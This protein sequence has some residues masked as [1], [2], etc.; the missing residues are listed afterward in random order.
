M[1]PKIITA[2]TYTVT[3]DDNCWWIVL[4]NPGNVTVTLPAPGLIFSPGFQITI[5][6]VQPGTQVTFNQLADDA[7][8]VHQI[9]T[10]PTLTTA[11][12]EG[13]VLKIQQDLNWWVLPT[14]AVGRPLIQT[15]AA[16]QALSTANFAVIT[17]AGFYSL[18][19]VPS[20]FYVASAHAC[21]LNAGAGDNGSQVKSADGKC[22]LAVYPSNI[23]DVREWGAHCDNATDDSV[24][25][26]AALNAGLTV[27]NSNASV[28]VPS[29][30]CMVKGNL[31]IPINTALQCSTPFP[32]AITG[33][34]A[35]NTEPAIV[36]DPSKTISAA[37]PGASISGCFIVASGITFPVLTIPTWTG[38]AVKD[39]GFSDFSLTYST[40]VG[41]DTAF[42][43]TGAR[44]YVHHVFADGTG[45]THAVIELDVGNTDS[46]VADY[47]K[48]QPI[49]TAN[50]CAAGRRPGTGLRVGS[51]PGPAGIWLD[52][53]V[54]QNF[55]IYDYDF[56]TG[57]IFGAIW[58][59]GNN[60]ACA[61]YVGNIGVHVAA[62]N[63]V[64]G[65]SLASFSGDP[66]IVVDATSTLKADFIASEFSG[67]DCIQLSG[68]LVAQT[69]LLLDCAGGAAKILAT[70]GVFSVHNLQMGGNNGGSLPFIKGGTTGLL[71]GAKPWGQVFFDELTTD[72]PGNLFDSN[73]TGTVGSAHMTALMQITPT[74]ACTGIGSTGTCSLPSP[75]ETGITSGTILLTPGG[76]GIAASGTVTVGISLAAAFQVV[77]WAQTTGGDWAAGSGVTPSTSATSPQLT[78]TWQNGGIP[79]VSATPYSLSY[80]CKYR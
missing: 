62:G 9:N 19:D 59:D 63:Y 35:L 21:T 40:I 15:N 6:P 57:A 65:G 3:Q 20:L 16:L 44:P 4:N 71:V 78:M 11:Q 70:T 49:G 27:L 28:L 29:L 30:R 55:D 45:V 66:G 39:A 14:G 79:L 72:R 47:I 50:S 54:S 58:T 80:D 10:A 42:Y 37:G 67:T 8:H 74:V 46:G 43:N 22:W 7:G 34:A 32:N 51:S 13:G 53:I 76:S 17:R 26:Q 73:F 31:A 61:D 18:G 64:W 75:P 38:I 23:M 41:F 60:F 12:G 36:L 77:C 68:A 69:A 25:F 24:A 52:Q 56:Q 48:I 2:P 33:T 1:T 5:L